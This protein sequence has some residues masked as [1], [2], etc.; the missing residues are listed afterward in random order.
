MP[1]IITLVDSWK[2]RG[3]YLL[4]AIIWWL[5]ITLPIN[6][7]SIW[8]G[9]QAP[10]YIHG[11]V[12]TY[13]VGYGYNSLANANQTDGEPIIGTFQC[14]SIVIQNGVRPINVYFDKYVSAT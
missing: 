14:S 11:D 5:V 8:Y 2:G 10:P 4:E 12:N 1:L 9:T 6:T 3:R 13:Y 7:V